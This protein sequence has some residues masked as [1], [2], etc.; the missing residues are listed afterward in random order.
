MEEGSELKTNWWSFTGIYIAIW[1]L[2]VVIWFLLDMVGI[3]GFNITH[4][5]YYGV[6]M[7]LLTYYSA[8]RY[9]ATNSHRS[10]I[11]STFLLIVI[12]VIIRIVLKVYTSIVGIY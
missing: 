1:A 8:K 10:Y 3:M 7:V 4:L 6:L 2:Y 5:T 9:Y 11:L 12:A